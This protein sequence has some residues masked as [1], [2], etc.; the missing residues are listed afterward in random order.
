VT[1]RST[2]WEKRYVYVQQCHSS[3]QGRPRSTESDHCCFVAAGWRVPRS[4]QGELF[5]CLGRSLRSCMQCVQ[6]SIAYCVLYADMQMCMVWCLVL[7]ITRG[8]LQKHGAERVRDTPI[9]E[10]WC[11]DKP[12]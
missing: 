2:S 1:R 6:Q 12:G 9:T 4:L 11:F 10:V 7:Q 3:N 8:L 5:C